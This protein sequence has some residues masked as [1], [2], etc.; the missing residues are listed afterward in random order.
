[1]FTTHPGDPDRHRRIG[2]GR[3]LRPRDPA[4]TGQP[5]RRRHQVH[6]EYVPDDEF[7]QSG[8]AECDRN[9]AG[10]ADRHE[11]A[12]PGSDGADHRPRAGHALPL[13][14][15]GRE[16][17]RRRS[18]EHAAHVHD[19]RLHAGES[20][21]AAPT[22]TCASR[23]AAA[24]LLDCRAYE[25]VSARQRRR[26][27]RRVQPGRRRRRRSAATPTRRLRD[28]D[29]R[30]LYGVHDGGIPGTGNPTN[31]G[32]DPYVA[33]RGADGWTTEYVGIPGRWHA[34]DRALQLDPARK[35]TPAS[36]RSPSA[37][38]K[39]A[40]RASPTAAPAS[41]ST[42]PTGELVQGMA[43]LDPASEREP[44]RVHRQPPLRRRQPLRLRL[45][46]AVRAGRQRQRR[47]LDLR[48]QP[49]HGRNPRRLEDA[50]R[51]DDDRPGDRRA[52]HLRGRLADRRRPAG[53]G[54]R[55]CQV[56]A[57]L[58]EHRRLRQNRRPHPR[59]DRRR[60]L[61]RHDRRRLQGLLHHRRRAHHRRQ[62]GHRRSAD[63][64]EAEVGATGTV[65]LSRVSTG[66]RRDRQHRLL[67]ALGKHRP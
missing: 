54:S 35:P 44:R 2:D 64:Y 51:R 9:A 43:G 11:Q 34:V 62:P 46:V 56:L 41:R 36:T 39:S 19:L 21:T 27:R 4:R 52:R 3:A 32:V 58:H 22:P 40:R 59:R 5:E 60:P 55:Q 67:P 38:P 8:L 61:R 53:L 14:G 16:R 48:P 24:L 37:V 26:L 12:Q 20:T 1:M 15:G 31:R 47:R 29:P 23:R 17:G 57:P 33:T 66:S 6:F 45:D 65:A 25:L 7:Q 10:R 49:E 50:R 13:P 63:L 18:A 30:V 42:S 28:G